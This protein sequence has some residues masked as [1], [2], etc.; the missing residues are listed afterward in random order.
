MHDYTDYIRCSLSQKVTIIS[1]L[2][3]AAE[4]YQE[5]A[6]D[7]SK[8]ANPSGTVKLLIMKFEQQAREAKET[9]EAI[10]G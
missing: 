10:N 7:L 6:D 2:Y 4:K 1:A 9:A 5:L 8:I 3:T